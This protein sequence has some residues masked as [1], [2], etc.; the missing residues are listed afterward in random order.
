MTTVW[1][2][3][4]LAVLFGFWIVL[5]VLQHTSPE[6]AKRIAHADIF[7]L[8][9]I[10][11]FF[12]PKPGTID[13]LLLYRLELEDMSFSAWSPVRYSVR[14]GHYPRMF[15]NPY[16]K[17]NKATADLVGAF[18]QERRVAN[19]RNML[20]SVPYLVW[21]NVVQRS[22]CVGFDRVQFCIVGHRAN[23][24]DSFHLIISDV[25]FADEAAGT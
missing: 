4:L 25:H 3:S 23:D 20:L 16:K 22:T 13:W 17:I 8:V 7:G 6:L 11:T 14:L 2:Q 15:I 5:T 18:E 9:P 24:E 19:G 12:A 10:W 1:A 21:L